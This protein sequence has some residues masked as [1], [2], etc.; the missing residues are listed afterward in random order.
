MV[1]CNFK[2]YRVDVKINSQVKEE[3]EQFEKTR[4]DTFD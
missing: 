3:V 4:F 1:L 2:I